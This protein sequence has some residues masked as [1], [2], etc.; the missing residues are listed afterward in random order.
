M[1]VKLKCVQAAPARCR[2]CRTH[3]GAVLCSYGWPLPY[4][5]AAALHLRTHQADARSACQLTLQMNCYGFEDVLCQAGGFLGSSMAAASI[6]DTFAILTVSHTAPF[7]D[8]VAQQ[9]T[10]VQ[11]ACDLLMR[12]HFLMLALESYS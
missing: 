1:M 8:A 6:P 3:A 4:H 7:N 10:S 2:P 12:P 9:A 5:T 11:S